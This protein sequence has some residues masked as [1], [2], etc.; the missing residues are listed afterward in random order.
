MNSLRALQR[1]KHSLLIL[2]VKDAAQAR[3]LIKKGLLIK[4]T[5]LTIEVFNIKE[6]L[7]QCFNYSK[8]AMFKSTTD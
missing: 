5:I 7:T 1:K 4:G 8:L 6:R 3:N 2:I